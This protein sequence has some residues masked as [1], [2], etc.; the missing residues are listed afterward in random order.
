MTSK[1]SAGRSYLYDHTTPGACKCR[2]KKHPCHGNLASVRFLM[3]FKHHQV[4]HAYPGAEQQLPSRAAADEL[5][6]LPRAIARVQSH[7]LPGTEAATQSMIHRLRRSDPQCSSTPRGHGHM[8][9]AVAICKCPG[10]HVSDTQRTAMASRCRDLT[11]SSVYSPVTCG[12][13]D[14]KTRDCRGERR[15]HLCHT[16][17]VLSS[18]VPSCIRAHAYRAF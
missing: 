2:R 10:M 16:N 1:A 12:M 5:L 8:L 13:V 11:T 17:A 18:S 9:Y 4:V 14:C 6:G 15:W 3:A 7:R